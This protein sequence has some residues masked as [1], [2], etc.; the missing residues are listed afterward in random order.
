MEFKEWLLLK[1][2]IEQNLEG[3]LGDIIRYAK[4]QE[5]AVLDN[6]SRGRNISINPPSVGAPYRDHIV[7]VL[8][9]KRLEDANWLA[10]SLG[11]LSAKKF[12]REDLEMAVDVAKRLISSG[13]LPK[14]EIGTKGWMITGRDI[15]ERVEE[16]IKTSQ[17]L[18][19]RAQRKL[20]KTGNTSTDDERL[21]KVVAEE[22]RKRLYLVAAMN[23]DLQ[24]DKELWNAELNAR[25]RILCKYGKETSWCTANADGSYHS[26]Y[27]F[28][29]IYIVHLEGKPTYQFVD[30]NDKDNHQFMDESDNEVT[31]LSVSMNNFL[32]SH[33]NI[34]CYEMSQDG[35][36]DLEEYL[37][38]TPKVQENLNPYDVAG[39]LL[40]KKDDPMSVLKLLGDN[41]G[42]ALRINPESVANIIKAT[43]KKKELMDFYLDGLDKVYDKGEIAS[44]ILNNHPDKESALKRIVPVLN[45]N[46]GA[47][48]SI[49]SNFINSLEG[50]AR[51]SWPPAKPS[52]KS[53]E[54]MNRLMDR[55]LE[56]TPENALS[57]AK[58][59]V[60][61][62]ERLGPKLNSVIGKSETKRT[63][64]N[65]IYI[66]KKGLDSILNDAGKDGKRLAEVFLKHYTDLDMDKVRTLI[67]TLAPSFEPTK[68]VI[69]RILKEKDDS[70][71]DEVKANLHKALEKGA[72]WLWR[73]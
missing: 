59:K 69:E 46:P 19:N 73:I 68:P 63:E 3:W 9:E 55:G 35:F 70:L 67:R 32:S 2:S 36:E 20:R 38:S 40:Q 14:R 49:M 45:R 44:I 56:F 60:A 39:F 65:T 10:F 66:S 29:N 28:N 41:A 62:A 8:K 30:C 25:H 54:E 17:S 7:S 16:F 1:E 26:H 22:G 33:A 27:K 57:L 52:D 13:E 6:L 42:L 21:I 5:K 51:F 72:D 58:D 48:Y 11:Y 43:P 23:P 71:N 64:S 12:R 24:K 31:S 61:I 47:S 4:P 53:D 50:K 37:S 15:Q 34:D 18:S